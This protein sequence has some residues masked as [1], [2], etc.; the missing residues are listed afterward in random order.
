MALQSRRHLALYAVVVIPLLA[1]RLAAEAPALA[2]PL[3]AWQR[4]GAL[5]A[6]EEGLDGAIIDP[7][8]D[9]Q[10]TAIVDFSLP[11]EAEDAA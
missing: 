6:L 8:R 5:L 11:S 10:V 1:T 4:R 2:R 9:G 7:D 3:A